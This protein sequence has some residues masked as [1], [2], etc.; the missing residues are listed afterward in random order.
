MCMAMVS[1][2]EVVM[3]AECHAEKEDDVVVERRVHER[4]QKEKFERKRIEIYSKHA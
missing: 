2:D 1:R 4:I 3:E